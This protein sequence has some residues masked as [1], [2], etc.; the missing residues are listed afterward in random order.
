MYPSQFGSK[1]IVHK[2]SMNY[3]QIS[4]NDCGLFV[5]AYIHSLLQTDEPSLIYYDQNTMRNNYNDFIDSSLSY[6]SIDTL[7]N[8]SRDT[9]YQRISRP[10]YVTV[11]ELKQTYYGNGQIYN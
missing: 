5:L 10:F 1:I 7:A 8:Y 6:F 4:G 3:L 9:T 11:G 2:V